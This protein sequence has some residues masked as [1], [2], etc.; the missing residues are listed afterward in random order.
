MPLGEQSKQYTALLTHK[1]TFEFN[2]LPFGIKT[3][4]SEFQRMMDIVFGHLYH[5]GVLCYIDDIVIFANSL[6]ELVKLFDEV[7]KTCVENGL[8]LKMSKAQFLCSE[9][10]LLGHTIA[11][12]GIR[13]NPRKVEAVRVAAMPKNRG[14]LRSFLG[15]ASY[16]RRFVPHFATTAAPL[17]ALTSPRAPFVI[18]DEVR[19]AFAQLKEDLCNAVYLTAPG[20]GPFSIMTDASD[21]GVGAVLLQKQDDDMI[22]LEFASTRFSEAQRRWSTREREAFA[23]VWAVSRFHDYVVAGPFTVFSDHQSLQ[24]MNASTQGKVQRWSL[25]LQQYDLCISHVSGERN[26]I[27][28]WLSRSWS[29]VDHDELIE[30]V[31]VPVLVAESTHKVKLTSHE[32]APVVPS[33]EE[34]KQALA[35]D[36]SEDFAGSYLTP[37]G[38]R[39]STR[40][41]KLYVPK[42]LRE[43]VM[44]WFHT[45]KYGG[46]LGINGTLRRIDYYYLVIIDHASRFVV[47]EVSLTADAGSAVEIFKA[48]WDNIF[49]APKAVLTDRGSS[50]RAKVFSDYVTQELGSYHVFSSPYYPQGNSINEACH[51]SIKFSLHAAM[52]ETNNVKAALRDAVKVH[53]ATPHPSTRMSPYFFMFGQEMCFPGWQ[54]FR[55]TTAQARNRYLREE[56]QF[57]RAMRIEMARRANLFEDSPSE[58]FE[59][60]DWLVF[61]LSEEE[62]R[63]AGHPVSGSGSFAPRMSLPS[64]VVSV[65]DKALVV[66]VLGAPGRYRDVPAALCR[67]L[68]HEVPPTL[69]RLAKGMIAFESPRLMTYIQVRDDVVKPKRTWGE[70][71][72]GTELGPVGRR[73]RVT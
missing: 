49:S 3:S 40:S 29:D 1:G 33:L 58:K 53:N 14:E 30:G 11:Y 10:N 71:A 17:T 5:K 38:L 35:L 19:E 28:D 36:K 60:G 72:G 32:F 21:V 67:K 59:V 9:V 69:Q 27:A 55:S 8:Y 39:L 13:P 26:L 61:E 50:F 62:S 25:F 23:I 16:M 24:W 37:D 52:R 54:V 4:G 22:I 20:V 70:L 45:S 42:A 43:T 34:F 64:K 12:G 47:A 41:N 73:R 68:R 56:A 51:K 2:V 15:T 18:T 6:E 65:K 46:H 63:H 44:W 48:H 7:L 31:A 57:Q 66:Q